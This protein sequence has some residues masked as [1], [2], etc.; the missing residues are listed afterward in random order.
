MGDMDIPYEKKL[1]M[2]S[3]V[4]A[5]TLGTAPPHGGT[6]PVIQNIMLEIIKAP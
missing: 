1:V 4:I 5:S 3:I 2:Q 6:A